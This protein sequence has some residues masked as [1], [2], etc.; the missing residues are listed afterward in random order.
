MWREI[1][2]EIWFS[3]FDNV[4]EII[5]HP[6]NNSLSL[7]G[8]SIIVYWFNQNKACDTCIEED[9]DILKELMDT[10]GQN[11]FLVLSD[12]IDNREIELFENKYS[13]NDVCY[14]V[15]EGE[16]IRKLDKT[17]FVRLLFIVNKSNQILFP[18]QRM[19]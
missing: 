1:Q 4:G 14:K 11:K 5:D 2:Y 19:I 12:F 17:P 15:K 10:I 7:S 13:L 6:I 8:N 16:L 3:S 18:V 9:M